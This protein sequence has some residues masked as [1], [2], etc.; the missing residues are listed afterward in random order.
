V[1]QPNRPTITSFSS[2]LAS[3]STPW[4][5]VLVLSLLLPPVGLILA[6]Y[7]LFKARRNPKDTVLLAIAAAVLAIGGAAAYVKVYNSYNHKYNQIYKYSAF[8]SFS[9]PG[10]G[11]KAG[12]SFMKPVEFRRYGPGSSS[13]VA[14]VHSINTGANKGSLGNI[15]AATV[16]SNITLDQSY[17]DNTN[18]FLKS[19]TGS[20]YDKFMQPV[21]QFIQS[22]LPGSYRLQL[23]LPSAFS[24][25][26]I[27]KNAWQFDL[28]ANDTD[29]I[30]MSR[31]IKGKAVFVIGKKTFYYLVI[32]TADYNWQTN[33]AAWQKVLNSLK[34]DQ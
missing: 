29:K 26:N 27:P 4:L 5:A 30:R 23:S 32:N 3:G 28:S 17:L 11:D 12:L 15:W 20:D 21:K 24:S 6:I 7:L 33:N 9:L 1:N 34:V 22:S 14:L 13:I 31:N 25:N 10:N 18:A 2:R 16:N 8:D 19:V